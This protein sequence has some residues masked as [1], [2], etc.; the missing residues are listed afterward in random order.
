MAS[1]PLTSECSPLTP[2]WDGRDITGFATYEA[3]LG[4]KWLELL[5]EI[6]P[7][8]KRGAI[9]FNSETSPSSRRFHVRARLAREPLDAS[10][11]GSTSGAVILRGRFIG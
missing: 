2:C 5:S 3:T 7:G 1:T 11:L 4:G 6:A 9:M 10:S 8:L